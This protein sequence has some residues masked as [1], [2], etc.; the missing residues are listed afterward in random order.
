MIQY[1]SIIRKSD[2]TDLFKYGHLYV[3]HALTFDGLLCDQK[4][5]NN[6]WLFDMLTYRMNNFEYSFEYVLIHFEKE[7]FEGDS[8]VVQVNELQGVYALNE[9][10]KKEMSISFDPRIQIHVSPWTKWF[11]ELQQQQFV[12]QCL[13]GVDVI[14]KVFELSDDDKKECEKIISRDVIKEVVRQ[15]FAHERP[16]GELSLWGYLLRY[17]RHSFY[18][19]T[20]IGFF[21]DLIHVV[22][23]WSSKKETLAGVAEGTEAYKKIKGDKFE[24]ILK[25]LEGSNLAGVT[26]EKTSCDFCCVAPLFLLFKSMFGEGLVFYQDSAKFIEYGKTY[27]SEF[28]IVAYLLGI[29]LGYDKTYDAYYDKINLP[30]F[31]KKELKNNDI[32]KVP[33]SEVS[34]VIGVKEPEKIDAVSGDDSSDNEGTQL[35]IFSNESVEKEPIAIMH[36]GNP[37]K[38][39][40]VTVKVYSEEEIKSYKEQRYTRKRKRNK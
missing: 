9:E 3:Y 2:F 36:K 24:D 35:D 4:N 13:R 25:S 18:P 37:G 15:L 40:Y 12:A 7:K 6:R 11:D 5:K 14:W 23:N 31:N 22:C 33:E 8:F 39:N 10:A 21:Y 38:K 17:E 28:S 20:I 34:S 27:K 29:T 16:K 19:K 1:I 30:L 32:L 26:K